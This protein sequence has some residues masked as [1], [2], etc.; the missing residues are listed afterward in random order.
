MNTSFQPPQALPHL[1]LK[2][3]EEL[4]FLEEIVTVGAPI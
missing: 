1:C 3:L 2:E 4:L